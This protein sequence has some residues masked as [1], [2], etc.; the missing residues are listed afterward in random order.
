MSIIHSNMI[1]HLRHALFVIPIL[2]GCVEDASDGQSCN[3]F[4]VAAKTLEDELSTFNDEDIFFIYREGAAEMEVVI[5]LARFA[6][7]AGGH[8]VDMTARRVL[9]EGTGRPVEISWTYG[10]DER[11]PRL[12][13]PMVGLG[14]YEVVIER[15][16]VDGRVI[17]E[18]PVAAHGMKILNGDED[19]SVWYTSCG[20]ERDVAGN[21]N[22]NHLHGSGKRETIRAYQ[23]NDYLYGYGCP[24]V[25]RGS[26]GYDVC[27]GH[28]G[29]DVFHNCEVAFQ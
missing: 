28:G 12:E 19:E 3:A 25:L 21:N 24:D 26:G 4:S 1:N 14:H 23:G 29:G 22:A 9:P 5:D 8:T 11:S 6:P 18:G 7:Y 2:A 27:Y 15:L 20:T 13:I 16:A 10:E 17:A